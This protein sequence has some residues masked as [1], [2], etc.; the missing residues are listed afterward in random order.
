MTYL[1]KLHSFIL[2]KCIN[3]ALFEADIG[4][5]NLPEKNSSK[6]FTAVELAYFCTPRNK[7]G[8]VK[9]ISEI[10]SHGWAW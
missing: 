5:N 1:V 4:I 8:A 2:E 6:I 3:Y 7:R 9:H 10:P